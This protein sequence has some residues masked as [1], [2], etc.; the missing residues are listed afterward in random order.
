L[1][2]SNEGQRNQVQEQQAE[3]PQAMAQAEEHQE[4]PFLLLSD[5]DE[6]LLAGYTGKLYTFIKFLNT[7][8]LV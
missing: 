1:T 6:D 3:E 7:W 8:I 5:D 2:S 4:D